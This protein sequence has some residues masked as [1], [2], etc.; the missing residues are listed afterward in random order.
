MTRP[1]MV[2]PSDRH[3][4]IVKELC[5]GLQIKHDSDVAKHH[6][7]L[8]L[9]RENLQAKL[10][11]GDRVDIG[12]LLELDEALRRY[13]PERE[14]PEINVKIV[15]GVVGVYTCCHC[16]KRNEISDKPFTKPGPTP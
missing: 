5:P 13:L 12:D 10:L 6:R 8:R 15:S 4:R 1:T 14:Q 3:Q 11:V 2:K 16:H 9:A 7:H